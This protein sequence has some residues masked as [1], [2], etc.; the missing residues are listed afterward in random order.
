MQWLQ[1]PANPATLLQFA[2]KFGYLLVDT[3]RAIGTLEF[4][5]LVM[6]EMM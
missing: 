5:L 2:F 6:L 3:S 4:G 1:T